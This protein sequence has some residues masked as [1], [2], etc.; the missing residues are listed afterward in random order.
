[1]NDNNTIEFYHRSNDDGTI[2][3]QKD[4][5]IKNK[6]LLYLTVDLQYDDKAKVF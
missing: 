3:I 5:I 6:P 2:T 4:Q 1:M